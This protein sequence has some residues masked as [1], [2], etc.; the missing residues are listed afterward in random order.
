[1]PVNERKGPTGR[2]WKDLH[3]DAFVIKAEQIDD[4]Q[5]IVEAIAN[6]FG[7]IDEAIPPDIVEPG[8]FRKTL[9]ENLRKVRILDMHRTSSG[10]DAVARPLEIRE[11]GRN[12]LPAELLAKKP[13][14][15]GGLYIKIAFMLN[16]PDSLALFNRYEAGVLDEFSIGFEV[17]R[18]EFVKIVRPDDGKEITVRRVLELILWEVSCVIWGASTTATLSVKSVVPKQDVPLA[19]RDRAWDGAAAESRVRNWA[20]GEEDIDWTKYRKA[21]MWYD[22]DNRDQFGSYKLGY[23]D[24]VD[25]ELRAVPRGIFAIAAV[26]QGGRGGVNIP[27]EDKTRIKGIVSR[28]YAQMRKE[29]DDETIVPP[30][31]ESGLEIPMAEEKE[32]TGDGQEV[33]RLGDFIFGQ[34]YGVAAG[35]LTYMLTD[36]IIDVNEMRAVMSAFD[37]LYDT[38][39]GTMGEEMWQRPLSVVPAVSLAAYLK[40]A[41]KSDTMNT[42]EETPVSRT[43]SDAEPR[44]ALTSEQIEDALARVKQL[45]IE[46]AETGVQ[47]ASTST[48]HPSAQGSH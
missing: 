37:M 25:G 15:T 34:V 18:R 24:I 14:A 11:V 22:A 16:D 48:G 45:Q 19:T 31:D 8:S 3:C 17:V 26:L 33:Q 32:R 4:K 41:A 20:G 42:E 10:K 13:E 21:F 9:Q 2:V 44:T 12:E 43:S 28:W 40:P 38:L 29:F 36:G 23:A 7:I 35:W 46:Y 5:G 1:M 27:A 6:T 39:L 30:W 47:D